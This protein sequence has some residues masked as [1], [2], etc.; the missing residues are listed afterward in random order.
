VL[1]VSHQ[2]VSCWERGI[3]TIPP[4]LDLA[5]EALE[6]R[7]LANYDLTPDADDQS[8]LTRRGEVPSDDLLETEETV[9]PLDDDI[10]EQLQA[11][12]A[13]LEGTAWRARVSLPNSGQVCLRIEQRTEGSEDAAPPALEICR[14]TFSNAAKSARKHLHMRA[15][16]KPTGTA[17]AESTTVLRC[18]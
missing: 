3:R 15:E 13:E 12:T 8:N 11:F 14:R 4:L 7:A 18:G 1:G 5:L 17:K 9:T 2:A 16:R 10:T 6:R